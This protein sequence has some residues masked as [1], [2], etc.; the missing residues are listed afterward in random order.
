MKLETETLII[1]PV[2]LSTYAEMFTKP[3]NNRCY[4]SNLTP[5][6][7]QDLTTSPAH[8]NILQT[9]PLFYCSVLLSPK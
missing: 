3:A 8:I 2:K 4:L 6:T 9:K 5:F 1:S 7:H